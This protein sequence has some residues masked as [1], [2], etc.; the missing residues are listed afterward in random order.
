MYVCMYV[1]IHR[2]LYYMDWDED[3]TRAL[4]NTKTFGEEDFMSQAGNFA[5]KPA[6]AQ[7]LMKQQLLLKKEQP[8]GHWLKNEQ[9]AAGMC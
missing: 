9:E 4:D 5:R 1:C 8:S 7:H 6:G 3:G 2:P